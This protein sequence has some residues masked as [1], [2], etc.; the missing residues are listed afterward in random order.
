MELYNDIAFLSKPKINP[1]EF[2]YIFSSKD[3]YANFFEIKMKKQ[4]TLYKY[5]YTINPTIG[6]ADILIRDK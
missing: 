6:S 2:K 5:P 4:L 3:I 1:E